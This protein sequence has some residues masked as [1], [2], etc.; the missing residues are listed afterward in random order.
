MDPIVSQ[1]PGTSL[2]LL[3]RDVPGINTHYKSRF[4]ADGI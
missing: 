1:F 4:V 3:E 2:S